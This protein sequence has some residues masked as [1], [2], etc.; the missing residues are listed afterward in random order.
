M[1]DNNGEVYIAPG[2]PTELT[3]GFNT[4]GGVTPP[5]TPEQQ[6]RVRRYGG[7]AL[8]TGAAAAGIVTI[9]VIA[10]IK[11]GRMAFGMDD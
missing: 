2:L 1:M 9:G 7:R 5:L 11:I 4:N 10:V 3:Q 8:W 6:T